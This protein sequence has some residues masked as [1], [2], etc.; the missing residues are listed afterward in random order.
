M[1]T[2][3]VNLNDCGGSQDSI[4]AFTLSL[5]LLPAFLKSQEAILARKIHSEKDLY[6]LCNE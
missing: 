1:G 2:C 5:M 3:E 6:S 4:N